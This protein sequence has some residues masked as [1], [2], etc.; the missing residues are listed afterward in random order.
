MS[1]LAFWQAIALSALTG[2]S[3]LAYKKHPVFTGSYPYISHIPIVV[4]L[5]CFGWNI[6][7]VLAYSHAEPLLDENVKKKVNAALGEMQVSWGAI[8]CL[9]LLQMYFFF[10][11]YLGNNPEK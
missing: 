7:M 9:F 5:L 11:G 6:A 8:G 3:I 2:L 1:D 4:V 10:L